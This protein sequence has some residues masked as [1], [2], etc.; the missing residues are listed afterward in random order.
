MKAIP[1]LDLRG[2]ACVQLIG[3]SYDAEALRISDPLSVAL[4]WEDAGFTDLHIVD[5]DAATGR[6]SNTAVVA[7]IVRQSRLNCQVGGG[8][9][10]ESDLKRLADIGAKRMVV[11]TRA[12]LDTDW[13]VEMSKL[14]PGRLVLAA[15][16]VERRIVTHG[17]Q[18]QTETLVTDIVASMTTVALAG[19]LVTAVHREGRMAGPDLELMRD[20]IDSTALQV[21]A[22]G[23]I[24][25][26]AD[27]EALRAYGVSAAVLGMAL[28]TGALDAPATARRFTQ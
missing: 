1:A 7:A 14:F 17:W 3:G 8:L 2:G 13:L 19:I 10:D 24:A 25:S 9:R 4:R 5:L 27:L 6:G 12:L 23:G 28:Y 22:S 18:R 15:D 20:V 16:V 26:Q 21:Q 11:G